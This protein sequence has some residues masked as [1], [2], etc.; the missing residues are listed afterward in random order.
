VNTGLR[1]DIALHRDSFAL[2]AG[3]DVPAG[4][5]VAVL[6]P[7]GAGKTTLLHAIAGLTALDSGAITLDGDVLEDTQAGVFI[8]PERRSI[9]VVFQ[10][11]LLFHHLSSL[12]NIAFGLR[13]RGV[14]PAEARV[15]AHEWLARVGLADH[16]SARPAQLSGGQ[17]QR[18]ALVRALI[19]E[20]RVL[21]LDEPLSALDATTRAGTRRDLRRHLAEYDGVRI[22]VTH[23]PIEAAA[24]ADRLVVLE[25]GRVVQA[26]THAEISAH[27]RS[28]YVAD[29]VGVNLF[30]GRGQ[31]DRI[32]VGVDAALTAASSV[33]GDVLA[34]VHPRAVTLHRDAPRGSARNV[35]QGR[36]AVIDLETDRVRV[37][38]AGPIPI[39][40]E[41]THGAL[42]E[43]RL[44]DGASVWVSVKATEITIFPA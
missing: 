32:V 33:E 31:R 42:D 6:G 24:L 21:L 5:T 26:G 44:T 28:P 22:V 34:V 43:L 2:T 3:L 8:P 23:D 37:R 1:A 30:R 7:N 18:V 16:A 14:K 15:R 19:C 25:A 13:C 39:V 12:D 17:A 29:L 38:V 41:I 35:W 40:A 4:E 10:D 27:P 9:G 20:P 36:V 11:Y